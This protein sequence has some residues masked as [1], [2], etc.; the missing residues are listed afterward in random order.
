METGDPSLGN[1]NQDDKQAQVGSWIRLSEGKQF[2]R[3]LYTNPV[4]FLCTYHNAS[5]D[6]A[7]TTADAPDQNDK[8]NYNRNV[9]IISWLTA[10]DNHGNFMMSLNRRRHTA[11]RMSYAKTDF[12]LCVPVQGMEDLVRNVGGVSGKWGSKF[13]KE[14]DNDEVYPQ[15]AFQKLSKRQQKRQQR[16]AHGVPGLQ[17]MPFGGNDDANKDLSLFAIQGTVAHLLC[18]VEKVVEHVIDEDHYLITAKVMDAYCQSDYWDANNNM[19]R[20]NQESKPYL[21][22]FGS[23]TFGYVVP[24]ERLSPTSS[25]SKDSE[26]KKKAC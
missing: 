2:S 14:R 8:D 3:L 18:Q 10:T 20:P 21:S 1:M 4:C 23:Q 9:M 26:K 19:F 24:E 11:T 15:E 7:K 13:P 16:F 25:D 6:D 12:V 22:F 5:G 17:I